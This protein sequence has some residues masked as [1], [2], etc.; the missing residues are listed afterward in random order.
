MTGLQ[1]VKDQLYLSHGWY[2]GTVKGLTDEQANFLPPGTGHPIGAIIQHVL[3]VEDKTIN[4]RLQDGQTLW[5]RE[6]WGTRA[7]VENLEGAD[8]ATY[9]AFRMAA[10]AL[11][12]YRKQVWAAS[13]EYL[14]K[15][16]ETDLLREI[17]HGGRPTTVAGTLGVLLNHNAIHVG[18]ISA[19]KGFQGLRGSP[20]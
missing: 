16:S 5:E 20:L 17:A 12:E 2:L 15:L 19:T 4:A 14:A 7:A 1:F 9:R 18:E 8:E 3:F 6:D 11:D 10:A 13:D